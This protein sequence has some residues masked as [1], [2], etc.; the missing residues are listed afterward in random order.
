MRE[1]KRQRVGQRERD[2]STNTNTYPDHVDSA[3]IC[4]PELVSVLYL[5]VR[6]LE[7]WNLSVASNREENQIQRGIRL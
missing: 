3:T 5:F 4:C 1:R 6:E 2:H 7:A